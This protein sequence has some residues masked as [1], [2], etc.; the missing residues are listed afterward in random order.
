MNSVKRLMKLS[1][2]VSI[3]AAP[4]AVL[5]SGSMQV[6]AA[7]PSSQTTFPSAEDASR[8]LLVAVENHDNPAL[9]KILG[10][11]DALITSNDEAQDKLD[12]EQFVH[13][14]Q[15]MHRLVRGRNGEMLLYIGAENWTFPIPLVSH[16]GIWRYDS[17]AGEKEVLYRRIGENEVS[18]IEVCQALNAPATKTEVHAN[19]NNPVDTLLA[20]VKA[21]RKPGCIAR[22]LLPLAAEFG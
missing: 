15:Q 7:Q 5:L 12:R 16:N 17:D 11:R 9:T 21:S 4:F 19:A 14:Y 13:K 2:S 20:T 1:L 6:S 3:I 18:A 22:L 8:A 10:Q